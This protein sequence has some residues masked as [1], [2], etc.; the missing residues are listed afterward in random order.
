MPRT[1]Q[2]SPPPS[3]NVWHWKHCYFAVG[4]QITARGDSHTITRIFTNKYGR[5][6]YYSGN[7]FFLLE[8][9]VPKTDLC[10]P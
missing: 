6:S 7:H 2:K 10:A 1:P 3:D 9:L 8:E 5:V 4:D